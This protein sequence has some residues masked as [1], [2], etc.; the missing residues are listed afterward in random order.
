M[1]RRRSASRACVGCA[2]NPEPQGASVNVPEVIENIRKLHAL[3]VNTDALLDQQMMASGL[4]GQPSSTD[5]DA[6]CKRYPQAPHVMLDRELASPSLPI[7]AALAGRMSCRRYE[8]IPI[9]FG[10]LCGVMAAA[11]QIEAGAR[12][13][14]RPYPSGGARYPVELYVVASGV[15]GL[16]PDFAYHYRPDLHALEQLWS[17]D[18][19]VHPIERIV[20]DT[21]GVSAIVVLTA[22]LARSV[23]RYGYKTYPLALIEAGCLG[24]TIQL[25]AAARGLGSIIVG[26]FVAS[27]VSRLLDLSADEIPLLTIGLG[28][29]RQP[30]GAA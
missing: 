8:R 29:P 12:S 2:L 9:S 17:A 14:K 13:G 28:R 11:R 6:A 5:Q 3:T 23:E 21:D 10:D 7:G 18:P 22:V 27:R 16:K 26:G 15:Q 4:A 25:L 30:E 1:A 24:Q 19:A 20:P